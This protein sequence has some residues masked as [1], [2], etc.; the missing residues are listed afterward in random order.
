MG[1]VMRAS[2]VTLYK[3][4]AMLWALCVWNGATFAEAPTPFAAK[5][6]PANWVFVFKMNAGVFPSTEV[7]ADRSCLFG[8]TVQPYGQFSQRYAVASSTAPTLV[9]GSGLVGS[10]ADA[11][12]ATFAQIYSGQLHYVVWNDQFY[13][14]PEI[15]GCAESCSGPWGHSKGVLAWNDDGEGVVLQV[16]T[17]S[18][19]G[20]GNKAHPRSGEGNTLGCISNNNVKF[21]QHFFAL[22]LSASDV[23]K[24]LDALAT[25]SVVTNPNDPM[26][27]QNGGPAV[28]QAMARALG[29][30]SQATTAT[31]IVLSSG[32]RL[33]AKP[34][35]L[36]VPP[37]QMVSALLGGID[38]RTATWWANPTIPS[39]TRATAIACW[40]PGLITPGAVD[41]AATG[42]WAG[43]SI[44]LKGGP[45][46]NSNHAKIGISVSGS[47]SIFGDLNQQ[48]ALSGN[49]KRSQNGR[50]GLFFVVDNAALHDSMKALIAGD[51]V[52]TA[53]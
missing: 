37:W 5:D 39:T 8:G 51:S 43:K 34:S 18:W 23:E 38:L 11:V 53:P 20:A 7:I 32:V 45:A 2:F 28:I 49:C 50:G 46:P 13:R 24:V 3:I 44:G 4:I 25:A 17:P 15:S 9:D 6:N 40:A 52:P 27:V 48:G 35:N 30:K 29:K 22:K 41:N 26:I 42:S 16:T 21:S 14:H 36:A 33:I 31:S 47:Y 10:G 19:P 12:G 1:E